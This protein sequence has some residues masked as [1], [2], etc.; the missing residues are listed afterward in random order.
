MQEAAPEIPFEVILRW[1]TLNGAIALGMDD[2]LGT[3]EP[4]KRPGLVNISPFDH[5]AGKL[6]LESRA[7]RLI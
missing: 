6:Q 4:G 7:R 5:N 2:E 1:A 3:L